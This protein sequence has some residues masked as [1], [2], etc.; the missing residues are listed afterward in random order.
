MIGQAMLRRIAYE[1]ESGDPEGI[2]MGAFVLAAQR[3]TLG[4]HNTTLTAAEWEELVTFLGALEVSA[5]S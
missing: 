1:V 2:C 5:Q 3:L 4:S